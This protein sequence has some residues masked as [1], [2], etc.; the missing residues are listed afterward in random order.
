[1]LWCWQGRCSSPHGST[2]LRVWVVFSENSSVL[3]FFFHVTISSHS[4]DSTPDPSQDSKSGA[5]DR[6]ILSFYRV[7]QLFCFWA[8][9]HILPSRYLIEKIHNLPVLL[10]RGNLDPR[11]GTSFGRKF[12]FPS[13][14]FIFPFRKPGDPLFGWPK[15]ILWTD[16]LFGR[17]HFFGDD[18][19]FGRGYYFPP[20]HN[21]RFISRKS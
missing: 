7:A 5:A 14:N 6:R 9:R 21:D 20:L 16:S 18:T 15:H 4:E 10:S 2:P 12:I 11:G 17:R 1:M 8:S 13:V 19:S 3:P